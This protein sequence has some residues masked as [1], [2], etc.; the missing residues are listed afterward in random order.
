MHQG[1]SVGRCAVWAWRSPRRRWCW[2]WRRRRRPLT[3]PAF[4]R[5]YTEHLGQLITAPGKGGINELNARANGTAGMRGTDL[6]VSFESQ[7]RLYFL[8]GDT[9]AMGAGTH[10]DDSIAVTDA[11]S[12]D[13]F[14]MPRLTWA[15]GAD[16]S[17]AP[18]R[19]GTRRSAAWR[20]P[21][22]ASAPTAGPTCSS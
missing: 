2:A 16:A 11:V 13:R 1:C 7:G 6:G 18:L 9:F 5:A 14:Q 10:L 19:I 8:F 3:P 21:W 15:A 17:F 20:S 22:R 4:Q 12:A